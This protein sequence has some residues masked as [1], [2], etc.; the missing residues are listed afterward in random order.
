MNKGRGKGCTIQLQFA[1]G[2]TCNTWQVV[3]F[4]SLTPAPDLGQE[5]C[6]NWGSHHLP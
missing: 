5:Y 6:E 2:S 4:H 3:G 1:I